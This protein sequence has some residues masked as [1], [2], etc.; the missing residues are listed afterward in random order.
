MTT[1]TQEFNTVTTMLL[2]TV[3]AAAL[4][5]AGASELSFLGFVAAAL[6]REGQLGRCAR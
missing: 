3:M 4:W 6:A 1:E 5:A 2:G